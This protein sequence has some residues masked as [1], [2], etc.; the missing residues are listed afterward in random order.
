MLAPVELLGPIANYCFLRFFAGDKQKERHQTRRYSES[1]P[2]KF[3]ELEQFRK[4]KN[5]FWPQTKELSNK[6]LWTV[7]GVGA[8]TVVVEEALRSFH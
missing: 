1:H 3:A 4:E 5:A 7:L 8:L 6:W 2:A